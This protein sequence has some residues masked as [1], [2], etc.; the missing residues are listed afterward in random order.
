MVVGALFTNTPLA[1]SL[2]DRDDQTAGSTA[3]P[4]DSNRGGGSD[5]SETIDLTPIDVVVVPTPTTATAIDPFGGDGERND[6]AAFAIDGDDDTFWRTE[7][8]TTPRFSGL[9]P[10]VGLVIDLGG[11]ARV[12]EVTLDTE[13]EGWSVELYLGDDFSGAIDTWGAPVVTGTDLD[14]SVDFDLDDNV[15]RQLL[16]WVTDHGTSDDG[17]DDDD[18]PDRRFELTEVEIS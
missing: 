18:E 11:N 6:T 17:T 3:E 15:G 9:K 2:L 12:S 16:I 10:G 4:A 1:D 13:S 7:K 14:D 5:P 8:Y